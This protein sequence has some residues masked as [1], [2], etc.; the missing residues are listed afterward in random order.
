MPMELLVEEYGNGYRPTAAG[1]L[2][3]RR[4]VFRVTGGAWFFGVAREGVE[5]LWWHSEEEELEFQV[6]G[7]A[8]SV[9][10]TESLPY[11]LE[12]LRRYLDACGTTEDERDA[13]LAQAENL[14]REIFV[15]E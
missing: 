9:W 4:F 6:T 7:P 15:R 8:E 11:F 5:D 2:G 10:H 3:G 12:G 14:A 13:T 1:R